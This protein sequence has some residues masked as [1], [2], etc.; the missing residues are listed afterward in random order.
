[1][2]NL[3]GKKQLIEMVKSMFKIGVTGYVVYGVVRDAM[4]MVVGTI[5]GDTQLT[6]L[7]IRCAW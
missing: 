3:I 4:A 6:M 7:V 2:K 5:R 1:M